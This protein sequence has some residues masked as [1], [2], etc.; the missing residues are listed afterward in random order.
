MLKVGITGGI[1]SGKT[2]VCKI[3]EVLRVPV[4]YA[5]ERAKALMQTD[6]KLIHSVK[7]LFGEAAYKNGK[8]NRPFVAEKVF[9][10]KPLLDKLNSIVHPAVAADAMQWM[11]RQADKPYAIK[12]AALLFENGSYKHLDKI[13]LVHA[14]METRIARLKSR[15]N[16]TRAQITARMRH[17]LSDDEK[18][19]LADFIIY[20]DAQRQLIPQVL[21]IHQSL[22]E[23]AES[24]RA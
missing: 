7:E 19:K 10:D 1:G 12:E 22:L 2:T 16:A 9:N 4:Y 13:I 20:N 11:A 8:L 21:A 23:L 14:A 6:L 5:D 17:Q 18:M 24:G 3:F 15:D